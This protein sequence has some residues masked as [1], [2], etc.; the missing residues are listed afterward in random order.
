[1]RRHRR[2]FVVTPLSIVALAGAASGAIVTSEDFE[3]GASGWS[4]N[5]T[6]SS[7]AFT[8]HLGRHGAGAGI[9][10]KTYALT[11]TQTQVTID[12]D[13]Y[14]LD[15][16]DYELFR[17][18][19]DGVQ[20]F[21]EDFSTGTHYAPDNDPALYLDP[22][23]PGNVDLAYGGWGDQKWH[24]SGT[25]LTNALTLTLGFDSTLDQQAADESWGVDNVR[26]TDNR[27]NQGPGVIPLPGAAAG[28][29]AMLGL[30]GTRRSRLVK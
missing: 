12:F 1:M 8:Q 14:E 19:V 10:S 13:F 18:Y 9:L 11:G 15:S 17:V 7:A 21:S 6:D 5:A 27:Q 25:F 22:L 16:W 4:N 26:I 24:F 2:W 3:G 20:V 29:L 30:L 23:D 28:G